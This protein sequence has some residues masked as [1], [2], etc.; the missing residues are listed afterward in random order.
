M[1]RALKLAVLCSL[2]LNVSAFLLAIFG[3][4][5][6]YPRTLLGAIQG[7]F[8]AFVFWIWPGHDFPQIAVGELLSVCAYTLLFWILFALF[9]KTK[10]RSS[11]T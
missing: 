6:S 5:N 4:P 9:L 10:V 1:R 8:V 11:I 2:V 7:P 3:S